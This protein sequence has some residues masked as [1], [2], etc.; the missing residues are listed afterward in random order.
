MNTNNFNTKKLFKHKEN[1]DRFISLSTIDYELAKRGTREIQDA[2]AQS[3]NTYNQRLTEMIQNENR[4]SR[5]RYNLI[6][7]TGP[8]DMGLNTV[9]KHHETPR[10]EISK[11]FRRIE[12]KAYKVLD[13]PGYSKDLLSH[14][15]DTNNKGLLAVVINNQVFLNSTVTA[16]TQKLVSSLS[17]INTLKFME[18]DETLVI[19]TSEGQLAIYDL[20][21]ETSLVIRDHHKSAV[22]SID[23]T[24]Y[25]SILSVGK[26]SKTRI[27]DIRTNKNTQSYD[28]FTDS[29]YTVK[30]NTNNPFTF[31]TGESN[32]MLGIVDTRLDTPLYYRKAHGSGVRALTWHSTKRDTLFSADLLTGDLRSMNA[33]KHDEL[34]SHPLS[35]GACD[36]LFSKS[37]NELIVAQNGSGHSIEVRSAKCLGKIADLRGHSKPV[38]DICYLMG[39]D[40]ISGSG[41]QS[42][43]FWNLSSL[44]A[45][46]EYSSKESERYQRVK[47]RSSGLMIR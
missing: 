25:N 18:N 35:T 47:T 42:L 30:A 6:E 24:A 8:Y 10:Y 5:L 1:K 26:D 33:V 27:F 9:P 19:G 43:R 34:N 17:C 38:Y 45:D 23:F 21:K 40:I 44:Y 41:D 28:F 4:K 46:G 12:E 14:S 39:D 20:T 2:L 15:I 13:A 29:I 3:P 37:T 11:V 32:G 31:A 22:T 7:S 36:L 16:K